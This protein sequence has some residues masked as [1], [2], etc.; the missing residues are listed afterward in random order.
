MSS[1]A[2][3]LLGEELQ[4]LDD[5]AVRHGFIQ[6]VYGI[7]G[8]QLVLTACVG[9]AVMQLGLTWKKT[10]PELVMIALFASLALSLA[11]MCVFWC[12][13]ASMRKTP[14][15]YI[16]LLLFTLAESVMVGF[17]CIQY[18]TESVL[19][20]LGITALV[21]FALS[22][23]ACQTSYDF[24]GFGPYLFCALMVLCGFSF[25]LMLSSWMGLGGHEGFKMV[26]LIYAAL[27]ALLFS[28]YIVYDTQLIVGG[29]HAKLRFGVDDY[30][31][32]AI[33]LYIDIIQLFLYILQLMGDRR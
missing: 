3:P 29:K 26:N 5:T 22:L 24:T 21:V 17:V 11:V 16:L 1:E 7:L 10:H 4:G 12:R 18:T 2:E 23:F 31:M 28:A 27:G 15:N 8:S 9:G 33:S 19:I 13:P 6:K 14:Q 30:A 32:A 20:A 25:A